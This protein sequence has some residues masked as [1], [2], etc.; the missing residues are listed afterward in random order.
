MSTLISDLRYSLRA[1][2]SRPGFAAVAVLTLALGIGAN[3]AMFSVL[4]GLFLAPLPYPHGERLVDVYNTYPTSSLQDAGSSIPDYLDRKQQATSL[5]DLALYTGANL[6]LA[7]A[8]GQPERLVGLRATPSLF[9]TLGVSA[10]IGRVFGEEHAVPGNDKVVLLSHTLWRNRFGADPDIVGRSV[11]MSGESWTVIGVMPEGF[12]FPNRSTQMWI[13]FA[14]S[15]AERSDNA[16]GQ[17]F[18]RSIGRLREG[19]TIAQLDA[20]LDAIVA[21]NA[22]RIGSLTGLDEATATRAAG[23]ADFLRGGNFTGRAQSFRELQVGEARPMVLILQGAVGLVLLIAAANVANLLLTRLTARQ[24]ELS[25]RNAL[26]AS[27]GRIARQLLAESLLVGLAG[28]G[29]G[30]VLAVGLIELLPQIGLGNAVERYPIG[31][32]LPVLGFALAVSLASGLVAALVPVLS[33]YSS[34]LSQVIN[35]AGRIAGGGRL[36]GASR[37]LLVVLQMA[38]ATALL[39]GAGLLLRSFVSVQQQSPG[40][41]PRGLLTALVALPQNRYADLPARA[42][43]VDD[44]LREVRAIPGV[45]LASWTSVLPFSGNNSQGS[46]N[47]DG[48]TV[49]SATASPHGNQRDVDDDYFATMKIPLLQGRAFGPGDHAEAAPVVIIDQLLAEKYFKDASPL[50]QRLNRGDGQPWATVVGVVPAIKHGNLRDVPGKETLYW[51]LRQ[52]NTP[53]G[54]LLLRGPNVGAP[55]T[56]AALRAALAKVDP[57]QP[58]FNLMLMEDRIALSLDNQRAPMHLIGAFAALALLLSAIGIYAVL[59]FSVSQRTGELGVR[60][61]IGA[62]KREILGLVLRHG[63]RLVAVGLG[64]GLVFAIGLGQVAKTQLFGVSPY[65]PLTFL[66]V[67]PLLAAIALVACWLPARRAARIDPLVALRYE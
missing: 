32:N 59:A 50:G 28:G 5:E 10:A 12:G 11:R 52:S 57:E 46:Y 39:V 14:F 18:S 25:V 51:P 4:H 35:D 47:I 26:G 36:A 16:R 2:L 49:D 29:V 66:V 40:F 3:T 55:E 41:E 62:G 67:P 15:D 54:S 65:D 8:G 48:L 37:N 24:K 45:E 30:S 1:L 17:E 27:R 38:L 23:Y 53:F 20:E 31:L 7:E 60:M 61:A 58:L 64:I 22:E 34:N 63:A 21:R 33:L 44:L 56:A 9:S 19:A 43:F 42:R 6:N 13:P